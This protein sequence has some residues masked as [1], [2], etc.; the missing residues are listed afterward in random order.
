MD[1]AQVLSRLYELQDLEYQ[2][3]HGSLMPDRKGLIGVR[4][5]DLWNLSKAIIAEDP[6]GF[7]ATCP[8]DFYEQNMLYGM[9]LSRMKWDIPRLLE[10]L[11]KFLPRIDNWAVC[12]CTA[13]NLK[14]VKKHKTE[15]KR[16][17]LD[18]IVR[19]EPYTI[20]FCI[21]LLM[22][23]YL[24]EPDI[25]SVLT[26]FSGIKSDHYYVNM[27]LSWALCECLV[28]QYG[29][30]LP[31]LEGKQLPVWVHNKTIQK[32]VESYRISPEQKSYLRS[33]KIPKSKTEPTDHKK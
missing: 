29:Q 11:D 26:V 1:Q 13:G 7:L 20:R 27:G 28:K 10:E 8:F 4:M 24:D 23:Y 14:V 5:P 17:I 31:L 25:T 12:D 18:R 16:W 22:D 2:K 3:F 21:C 32:A 9:V 19:P 15:V 33:L 30:T 6:E